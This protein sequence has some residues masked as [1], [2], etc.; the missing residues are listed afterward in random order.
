MIK[1]LFIVLLLLCFANTLQAK[2]IT[3]EDIEDKLELSFSESFKKELTKPLRT[4]NNGRGNKALAVAFSKGGQAVMGWLVNA[5]SEYLASIAAIQSCDAQ[6]AKFSIQSPC[7]I[8]LLQ[9]S[10]IPLGLKMRESAA[11]D[12][13]LLL[14]KIE[15]EVGTIYLG[16]SIHV[17]KPTLLP[18]PGAFDEA[19]IQSDQIALE[20]N[21]LLEADP[22]RMSARNRLMSAAPDSESLKFDRKLKKRLKRYLKSQGVN[23]K[24]A[25]NIHP[26]FLALQITNLRIASL[27][28]TSANGLEQHYARNAIKTG[29]VLIELETPEFAL[30]MFANLPIKTQHKMLSLV[31]G[32]IENSQEATHELVQ[33]W[34]KGDVE[35]LYTLVSSAFAGLDIDIAG[36]LLD[37]RNALWLPKIESFL[38]QNKT[39]F[40]LV[41]AGH[42]GGKNGLLNALKNKGYEAT[43]IIMPNWDQPAP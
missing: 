10:I 16:G 1:Q 35:Q 8:V 36:Q 37:D 7:E 20:I 27:G 15:G 2:G 23:Y 13:E 21:P 32:S 9:D 30:N 25:N 5:N 12:S 29:K 14:W 11:R 22:A 39:T 3:V 26:A 24:Q 38:Q 42:L 18:L 41:G 34:M 6:R 33:S 43:R 31:L 4:Y 19:F 40:V 28:Y 17:L